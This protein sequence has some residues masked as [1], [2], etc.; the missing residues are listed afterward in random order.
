MG[1]GIKEMDSGLKMT[2]PGCL[3]PPAA[4]VQACQSTQP[5]KTRSLP[6]RLAI[7]RN[8]FDIHQAD[9]VGATAWG[10]GRMGGGVSND[11]FA[12]Y[13]VREKCYPSLNIISSLGFRNSRKNFTFF[14][15][16]I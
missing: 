7:V 12:I 8:I 16:I 10:E 14:F 3:P 6:R 15:L 13:R 1:Y 5:R 4:L 11:D 9:N 2:P